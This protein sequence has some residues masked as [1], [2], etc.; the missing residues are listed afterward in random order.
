LFLS[1]LSRGKKSADVKKMRRVNNARC[2]VSAR[3]QAEH[4]S[5]L[6]RTHHECIAART[7]LGY[8]SCM[9]SSH[10]LLRAWYFPALLI[11]TLVWS[12]APARDAAPRSPAQIFGE[13]FHRVQTERLFADSKTFA[14]ATPRGVPAEILREY[15]AQKG[16]AN[17]SLEDFVA[18]H[19]NVPTAVTSHFQT[20]PREE[21]RAHIARLWPV[22]TRA[23]GG[24]DEAGSLLPLSTSY[25]V[26]GGRFREIYYWDSYFTMLGL[27]ASNRHDLVADM[28]ENFAGLIDRYGHIPNGNRT[29][30]LS[31]SQPPFFALMVEL[32]AQ[33]EGESALVKRLPQLQREYEFWMEGASNLPNGSVHRRVVRLADGSLLNRY[34]DDLAT[35]RDESYLE[36]IE[37]AKSS[38]RP[39]ADVYRDLRASAE[40][41]WDFSSRWFADGKTLGSIRTTDIVPVDLNSLMYQLELTIAHACQ[42]AKRQECQ[43]DMRAR[44]KTRKDVMVRLM[45]AGPLGAFVDYDWRN[46]RAL[47]QVTVATTYPLFVGLATRQQAQ[48]VARTIREKLL[49]PHGIA[50]TTED[51]GQ[52]WDA[53]NGWAPHQWIAIDGLRRNGENKLAA[54]IANTWIAE[55]ARVYCRTGKLV[56]KYNIRDAGEGAGGEYP[57][58]DGFGWTNGVLLKLLALYPEAG[59]KRYEFTEST[60]EAAPTLQ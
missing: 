9:R 14:D 2:R 58:Q 20:T 24:A 32:Q 48:R 50:T 19:F 10:P 43:R 15:E 8:K 56:E 42:V 5:P 12:N 33:Q 45:W 38:G 55:N 40:S 22:L 26:P 39:V 31:R 6:R 16:A 30:Y 51:T 54:K 57:V 47:G 35:P 13:L 37:T 49:E 36:D 1:F 46:K 18:L 11:F 7:V 3:L 29:Y 27:Q 17:F 53:P 28:V 4:I 23:P 25:V 44:A 41:G 34:W 52:Q 60:C 59:A 21:V